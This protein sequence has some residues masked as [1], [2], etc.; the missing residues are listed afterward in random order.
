MKQK[1]D[2]ADT[3][4]S[5]PNALW[6]D[7]TQRFLRQRARH[8]VKGNVSDQN[9][10]IAATI[11][12]AAKSPP[13]RQPAN[14]KEFNGWLRPVMNSVWC[15][16]AWRYDGHKV[17]ADALD[18]VTEF[19][20]EDGGAEDWEGETSDHT[21]VTKGGAEYRAET[22]DFVEA[23]STSRDDITHEVIAKELETPEDAKAK[24]K[25]AIRDPAAV[26]QVGG[27]TYCPEADREVTTSRVKRK[28]G[29]WK[30]YDVGAGKRLTAGPHQ[31][32]YKGTHANVC[33]IKSTRDEDRFGKLFAM[34][35]KG[36]PGPL[37]RIPAGSHPA[38]VWM[39]PR[40]DNQGVWWPGN[41]D[42]QE[43]CNRDH[44]DGVTICTTPPGPRARFGSAVEFGER[45]P[46]YA[47][48]KY[49]GDDFWNHRAITSDNTP[50]LKADFA[51]LMLKRSRITPEMRK[52]A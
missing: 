31:G 3:A 32:S 51:S 9:D 38:Q 36:I 6:T 13:S 19:Y 10:L 50:K 30:T 12:K 43:H 8:Y 15:D 14:Q 27:I 2:G 40:R 1:P 45:K 39:G 7:A 11:D 24:P 47:A 16:K 49:K 22:V 42:R 28:N 44:G 48:R 23:R 26:H 33:L 4:I 37:L 52:A 46:A 20:F 34:R 41:E 25:S 29:R 21:Y 17:T 18:R 35:R 5:I